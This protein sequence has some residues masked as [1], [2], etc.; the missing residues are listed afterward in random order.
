MLDR[1]LL[2]Q[3]L[4]EGYVRTQKHPEAPLWIYNYTAKTQYDNL[5][6]SI[7]IHCRGLILN[8][9]LEV[10]ARPFPKFFNWGDR[11]DQAF[12]NEPF[13]V[14]EKMDGSLGILYWLEDQAKLATRGAFTSDQAKVGSA[15]LQEKYA[16]LLPELDRTKTYLFEIIYPE[17]RVVV[18]YGALRDLILL[19]VIDT[20]TGEEGA[21]PEIGFPV[22]KRYDGFTEIDQLQQLETKNKE[23]FVIRFKSGLRYK[24]KFKEYLR[25]HKIFT[26]VS[27]VSIWEYLA[28]G[29]P[30]DEILESV[31]DELYQWIKT[32]VKEL[33]AAFKAIEDQCKADFKILEDRKATAAYFNSCAYP[34]VLFSMLDGK[35]YDDK[36]WRLVRPEFEQP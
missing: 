2:S 20:A 1:K 24:V 22:A 10:V 15:I 14:Y 25:L 16:H 4:S 11:P 29:Q 17:N 36:I 8:E 5:W 19:A 33:K 26:E 3:M 13:E 12:P 27:S 9:Q 21:L 34:G 31:P 7:T 28:T 18:D 23:G 6:N 32:K 30:F 35:R